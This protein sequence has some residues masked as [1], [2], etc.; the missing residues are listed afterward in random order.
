M[1]L[2]HVFI[3][4]DGVLSCFDNTRGKIKT[5]VSEFTKDFFASRL[6][7]Y[8]MIYNIRILFSEREYV[9]HVLSNSPNKESTEGKNLFLDKYFPIP[10][11]NRHFIEWR[12]DV[13]QAKSSFILNYIQEH[14]ID[15]ENV[16]FIDDD[17]NNLIDVE[18]IDADCYHPSKVLTLGRIK[19]ARAM[20]D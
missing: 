14:N 5:E 6:P 11:E 8:D 16:A 1:E 19:S 9:Y 7:V 20:F 17:Y 18:S 4:M 2:K 3:D 13:K 12:P 15:I 10:Y